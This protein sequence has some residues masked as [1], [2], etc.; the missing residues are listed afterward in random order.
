MGLRMLLTAA[1]FVFG[2][3]SVPDRGDI[4]TASAACETGGYP[5]SEI[6]APSCWRQLSDKGKLIIPSIKSTLLGKS[7][8]LKKCAAL[9]LLEVGIKQCVEQRL[10]EEITGFLEEHKEEI[11]RN[12]DLSGRS[13]KE[14]QLEK[15]YPL[16]WYYNYTLR[17]YQLTMADEITLRRIWIEDLPQTV[18]K[19]LLKSARGKDPTCSLFPLVR[20]DDAMIAIEAISTAKRCD[21][22]PLL[23][24]VEKE[25]K[26]MFKDMIE[27]FKEEGLAKLCK[28]KGN[29]DRFYENIG[30][31]LEYSSGR[32]AFVLSCLRK[33]QMLEI[34]EISLSEAIDICIKEVLDEEWFR[35]STKYLLKFLLQKASKWDYSGQRADR[36]AMECYARWLN[37]LSTSYPELVKELFQLAPGVGT[38]H[39]YQKYAIAKDEHGRYIV[40]EEEE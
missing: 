5:P 40:K 34:D 12:L 24:E 28:F 37:D 32:L 33:H 29:E 39:G 20:G 13:D 38:L 35:E 16:E 19:R 15:K 8:P 25:W 22:I 6:L 23:L 11:L 27:K 30:S 21:L 4:R 14:I 7:T 1:V 26:D 31:E 2:C 9:M 3:S 17:L 18:R 36:N 10:L